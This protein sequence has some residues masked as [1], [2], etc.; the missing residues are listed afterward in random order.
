MSLLLTD[1]NPGFQQLTNEIY[2]RQLEQDRPLDRQLD[3]RAKLL[4]LEDV[5]Y[6][7]D[8]L[9]TAFELDDPGLY[10][11]YARWV[12]QL[13]LPLMTWCTRERLRDIMVDHYELV[14][15]CAKKAA[16][17]DARP[18]LDAILDAAV[19]ATVDECAHET[20]APADP[21]RYRDERQRYLD[22]LL[23]A[24]SKGAMTLVV[25][26]LNDGIPLDDIYVAIVAQAMRT[27][28]S[29]WHR[30]EISVD[31]EH[32]CTSITQMALAQLYPVV[33]EQEREG[34]T[35]V[36]ACVGS[37]L[38]ELGARMVADLFEYHGWDS[39]YL[40][41]AVPVAATES[42]IREHRPDLAVLSVTMP[43]H[44]PLCKEA[45]EHLRRSCP[46]VRIAV[47]GNAFSSTEAWRSWGA[48]V[49]TDNAEELVRWAKDAVR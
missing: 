40:G 12:Y 7:V 14:R 47:G 37:E 24:D 39:V 13:L 6:N 18:R 5:R 46:D 44:L 2:R 23:R 34:R 20:P 31:A 15:S 36:V 45:V 26:F 3:E 30:H 1:Q 32:C 9:R 4:M 21:E 29:M 43:Q 16:P 8:F 22:C 38:H 35:V 42:A 49:R 17:A 10:A 33:F 25:Q 28:G 19:E 41:A 11:G 48:D 27:V